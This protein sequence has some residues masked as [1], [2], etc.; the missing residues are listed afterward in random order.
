MTNRLLKRSPKEPLTNLRIMAH[1]AF[2]FRATVRAKEKIDIPYHIP[3]FGAFNGR[4]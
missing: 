4:A 2:D 3:R 1:R